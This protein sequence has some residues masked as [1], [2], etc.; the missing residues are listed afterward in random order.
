MLTHKYIPYVH[1]YVPICKHIG[2]LTYTYTHIIP[3]ICH[4]YYM[5][6]NI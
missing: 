1:M 2:T 5:Y 6:I 3:Y 4:M